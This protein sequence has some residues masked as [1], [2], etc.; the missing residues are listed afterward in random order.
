MGDKSSKFKI[1]ILISFELKTF[2]Y[3]NSSSDKKSYKTI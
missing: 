1:E 2:K 3:G